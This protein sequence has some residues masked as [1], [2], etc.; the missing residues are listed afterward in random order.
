M[1]HLSCLYTSSRSVTL[2][3]QTPRDSRLG[4]V[5]AIS[6]LKLAMLLSLLIKLPKLAGGTHAGNPLCHTHYL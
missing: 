1:S 6:Y 3:N 4:F 5:W 2:Y